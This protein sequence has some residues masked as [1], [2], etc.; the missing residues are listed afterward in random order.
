MRSS[1]GGAFCKVSMVPADAV[2]RTHGIGAL[3]RS[4][5]GI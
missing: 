1:V 3:D 4:H 5:G 2:L